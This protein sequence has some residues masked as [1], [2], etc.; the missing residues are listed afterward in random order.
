MYCIILSAVNAQSQCSHENLIKQFNSIKQLLINGP[1][2]EFS[3]FVDLYV[4]N[5]L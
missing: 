3:K 4:Q 1:K 5:T 2:V